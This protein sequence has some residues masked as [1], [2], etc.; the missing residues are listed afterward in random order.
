MRRNLGEIERVV[1]IKNSDLRV[2]EDV[3]RGRVLSE[4]AAG[5]G[6]GGAAGGKKE[7]K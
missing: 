1:G 5:Q 6:Q 4:Q 2:V 3:L 7:G